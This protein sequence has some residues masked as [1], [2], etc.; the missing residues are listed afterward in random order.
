VGLGSGYWYNQYVTADYFWNL[1]LEKMMLLNIIC[2]IFDN[3]VCLALTIAMFG[4]ID[5]FSQIVRMNICTLL[6]KKELISTKHVYDQTYD[7]RK[8][9]TT[10]QTMLIDIR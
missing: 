8:I 1:Q 3:I 2:T 9:S 4:H 6:K 5:D 7:Q 10:I